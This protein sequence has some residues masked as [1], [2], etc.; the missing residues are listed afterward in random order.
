MKETRTPIHW[1]TKYVTLVWL[2]QVSKVPFPL[3][4]FFSDLEGNVS[5]HIYEFFIQKNALHIS[6]AGSSKCD[7]GFERH[8]CHELQGAE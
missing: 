2:I 3:V 5:Y 7:D 6:G 8:D 1:M 4:Q